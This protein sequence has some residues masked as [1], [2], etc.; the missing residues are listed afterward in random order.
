MDHDT[1][2]HPTLP[3]CQPGAVSSPLA[4][5]LNNCGEP[6]RAARADRG[7]E[8]TTSNNVSARGRSRLRTEQDSAATRPRGSREAVRSG[9]FGVSAAGAGGVAPVPSAAGASLDAPVGGA[10]SSRD[11]RKLLNPP[12]SAG[13]AKPRRVHSFSWLRGRLRRL[14]A[15]VSPRVA[16]CGTLL[17]ESVTKTEG[18]QLRRRAKVDAA[19]GEASGAS[20]HW[21]GVETCG[22][23]WACPVCSYSTRTVR[24]AHVRE[25][26]ERWGQARCGMLTLT[27]AHGPTDD[28]R[29]MLRGQSAALSRVTRGKPWQR[30]VAA[31]GLEHR[32]RGC[33]PTHSDTNGWHPHEH[34]LWFFRGTD[35][36]QRL[37]ARDAQWGMV[38]TTRADGE[39][40][41]AERPK[42]D[43]A[44]GELIA[45]G[46]QD[47]CPEEWLI[48]RWQRCV[49]AE[50]GPRH[51]PSSRVG[52]RLTRIH[53]DGRYLVKLGLEL[54]DPT[55][56][57]KGRKQGSRTAW[58][59]AQDWVEA[60]D[61][62]SPAAKRDA[63]LW[64]EYVGSYKGMRALTWSRGAEEALLSAA[65]LAVAELSDEDL[66]KAEDQ[67]DGDEDEVVLTIARDDYA[68]LW[69]ANLL[70]RLTRRS[71]QPDGLIDLESYA[72]ELIEQ[73]RAIERRKW[74]RTTGALDYRLA[75]WGE[76]A[77]DARYDGGD[78]P[79]SEL[80]SA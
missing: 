10:R 55:K 1:R 20:H 72:A 22:S 12:P 70:Y 21:H 41:W 76:D 45:A 80:L 63:A 36:R 60:A 49:E 47:A 58:Q 28:L 31:V 16:G 66:A 71:E 42:S 9:G 7:P 46:W 34:C 64:C 35:W 3:A 17:E 23:V 24:A 43:E 25:A 6:P 48:A 19:T 30:F 39:W 75:K 40:D 73:A 69:S 13:E 53:D 56:G 33:E 61:K 18:A 54:N 29:A 4:R 74:Q 11:D 67:K 37:H 52:T 59:I 78:Y 44:R 77:Y 50:M 8:G 62:R 32:I 68:M 26:V 38:S 27:I 14:T 15:T 57:K 5:G 2:L 79:R 51:R 65:T